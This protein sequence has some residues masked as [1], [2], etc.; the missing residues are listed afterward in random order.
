M[1]K[2]ALVIK[3]LSPGGAP[4]SLCLR[5]FTQC[6]QGVQL[7]FAKLIPLNHNSAAWLGSE[8]HRLSWLFPRDS[9]EV[10][11]EAP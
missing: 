3:V 9:T 10:D 7:H 5:Q 6:E 8:V 4:G 1:P 2:V 11:L